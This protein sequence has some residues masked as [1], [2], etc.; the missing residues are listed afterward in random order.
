M[1]KAPFLPLTV[2][3]K[4][5]TE[6]EAV[7]RRMGEYLLSRGETEAFIALYGD[8]GAGK[9]AFV[10]GLAA[11]V[12]P[13][14]FVSSPTYTVVNEY[15]GGGRILRHLDLYRVG[16]EEDLY[17]VGFFDFSGGMTAAEWCEDFALPE[18]FYR[19]EI[20]VLEKEREIRAFFRG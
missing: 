12:V 1:E 17:S 5:E 18:R 15:R 14:A 11:A 6:T 8:L 2:R 19:V 10:R 7:G 3:T 4:S 9:T 20:E 16:G 13:G